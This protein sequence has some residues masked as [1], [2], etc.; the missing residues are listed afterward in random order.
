M[1]APEESRTETV[2]VRLTPSEK[3]AVRGLAAVQGIPESDL[4][5]STP[6]ERI[7]GEFSRLVAR[8][9]VGVG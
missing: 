5:R 9:E 1:N 2:T 6:M 7:V 4:V 3:R 8:A